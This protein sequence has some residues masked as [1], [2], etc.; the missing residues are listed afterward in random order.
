[1]PPVY[2]YLLFLFLVTVCDIA[3]KMTYKAVRFCN[4]WGLRGRF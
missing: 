4:L 3:H 2:R 1:M